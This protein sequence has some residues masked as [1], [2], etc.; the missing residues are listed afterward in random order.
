[1]LKVSKYTTGVI[2][3]NVY[4]AYD[5]E[6]K[7]AVIVDPAANAPHIMK[8][9]EEQ[10]HLT[11]KAIVLTHGH[12]D[13]MM[14]GKELAEHFQIPIYA[15]EDERELLADAEQNL[16]HNF[17]VNVVLTEQDVTFFHAGDVLNLLG[18]EWQTIGTPGHTVGSVCFYVK[19]GMEFQPEGEEKPKVYPVLFSGD[20]LFKESF[21]RTDFPTGSEKAL[22]RSIM[23]KLLVLPAETTVFPGHEEQ[24]SIENERRYN[25]AA[26]LAKLH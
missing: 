19:D 21:G 5:S 9:I 18:R 15:C 4:F 3:T 24:T 2:Q 22:F 7:E 23:E 12:F 6:T 25:P 13:H 26:F 8:I 17:N 16:S 20:T 11:P 14:A 1:M 10:L